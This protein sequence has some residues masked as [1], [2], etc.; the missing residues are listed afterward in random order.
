MQQF[1]NYAQKQDKNWFLENYVPLTIGQEMDLL[2]WAMKNQKNF[3]RFSQKC[4]KI[5]TPLKTELM[6]WIKSLIHRNKGHQLTIRTTNNKLGKGISESERTKTEETEVIQMIKDIKIETI[7]I[8]YRI[9]IKTTKIAA[10]RVIISI[11]EAVRGRGIILEAI[12]EEISR[13]T[14][15]IM[16]IT[17]IFSS[18]DIKTTKQQ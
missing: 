15:T 5:K 1:K 4:L 7:K 17:A 13:L 18:N 6:P 16:S 14:I 11:D 8:K 3:S 10:D 2:R 12:I 9:I